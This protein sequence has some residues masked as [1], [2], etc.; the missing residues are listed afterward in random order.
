MP[1]C[2]LQ[3][4]MRYF[5]VRY[6]PPPDGNTKWL[7][8]NWI[9]KCRQNSLE[10]NMRHVVRLVKLYFFFWVIWLSRLWIALIQIDLWHLLMS[11]YSLVDENFD[12]DAEFLSFFVLLIQLMHIRVIRVDGSFFLSSSSLCHITYF[13]FHNVWHQ[14]KLYDVHVYNLYVAIWFHMWWKCNAYTPCHSC[15]NMHEV[16]PTRAEQ[17]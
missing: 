14:S 16:G 4:E 3:I 13:F 12:D 10:P 9:E 8:S 17:R 5:L 6:R 1:I 15:P 7:M 11:N 2:T